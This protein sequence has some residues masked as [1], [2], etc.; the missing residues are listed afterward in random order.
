MNS[1][2]DRPG[3]ATTLVRPLRAASPAAISSTPSST[4]V[5]A[6]RPARHH[7]DEQ[8]RDG[9]LL[10]DAEAAASTAA[11]SAGY[12]AGLEEGMACGRALSAVEQAAADRR[13]HA[14]SELII[15]AAEHAV[16]AQRKAITEAENAL[17]VAAFEIAEAIIGRETRE[18]PRSAEEAL[19][20]ALALAPERMPCLVRMHP[21]DVADLGD[22]TERF[23]LRDI[24]MQADPTIDAGDCVIS[25]ATGRIEWRLTDAI[26]R[27]RVAVL[28]G[29]E[30]ENETIVE[31]EPSW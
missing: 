3:R 9:G 20:G 5:P 7:F 22:V 17:V 23:A 2:S 28:A 26:E 15:A 19:L 27:A 6:T 13:S 10:A 31:S 16:T 25:L 11:W 30:S 12:E 21:S 4:P 29:R 14:H 1:S 18:S 8:L 24:S